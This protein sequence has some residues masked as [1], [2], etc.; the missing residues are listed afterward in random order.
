MTTY[1][2]QV[3]RGRP[4]GAELLAEPSR[5]KQHVLF[6]AAEAGH[7]D[8]RAAAGAPPPSPEKYRSRIGRTRISIL[9]NPPRIRQ[10]I[11]RVGQR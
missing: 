10:R 1:R 2:A 9:S 11:S 6:Y 5:A 8:V 3:L 7:V 4:G